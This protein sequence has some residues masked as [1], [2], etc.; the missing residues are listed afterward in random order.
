[1]ND[2]RKY[3]CR[4]NR[5]RVCVCLSLRVC[6]FECTCKRMYTPA[7]PNDC[8]CAYDINLHGSECVRVYVACSCSYTIIGQQPCTFFMRQ[9]THRRPKARH[10]LALA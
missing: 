5:A 2:V 3:E 1:M 8:V 7:C 6:M 4:Q 9:L 10:T